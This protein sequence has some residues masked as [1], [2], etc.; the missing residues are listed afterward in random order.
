[1]VLIGFSEPEHADLSRV[2]AFLTCIFL[3]NA[4]LET[5][6]SGEERGRALASARA[7]RLTEEYE[8]IGGLPI[9]PQL[10]AQAQAVEEALGGSPDRFLC[11]CAYRPGKDT[12]CAS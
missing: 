6:T 2:E 12:W 11:R 9:L 3:A 10:R 4:G 5:G 1:V 7:P 8:S